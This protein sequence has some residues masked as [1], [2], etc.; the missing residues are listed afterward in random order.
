MATLDSSQP[1][2][3]RVTYGRSSHKR[4]QG[5]NYD[6]LFATSHRSQESTWDAKGTLYDGKNQ[7]PN[8]QGQV[9]SSRVVNADAGMNET[10]LHTTVSAGQK[11]TVTQSVKPKVAKRGRLQSPLN[12][13]IPAQARNTTS[14]IF[15]VP[16]SKDDLES[17]KAA[18]KQAPQTNRFSHKSSISTSSKREDL[19]V[20][21]FSDTTESNELG[22]HSVTSTPK[23][24]RKVVIPMPQ[25]G[26]SVSPDDDDFFRPYVSLRA[27]NEHTALP[28]MLSPPGRRTNKG[29]RSPGGTCARLNRPPT[30][31]LSKA[32]G[33]QVAKSLHTEDRSDSLALCKGNRG[34]L[35]NTK[36]SKDILLKS[37]H[38]R[39]KETSAPE[40]L[41]NMVSA[42]PALGHISLGSPQPLDEIVRPGGRALSPALLPGR[43]TRLRTPPLVAKPL[44]NAVVPRQ[45]RR[46][47]RL[48]AE[49]ISTENDPKISEPADRS[50][51]GHEYPDPSEATVLQTRTLDMLAARP[52]KRLID[53][54]AAGVR[55]PAAG[56]GL[57]DRGVNADDMVS[58]D[59]QM[60]LPVN[61][62]H[63]L[64]E[65]Q[66][67][68]KFPNAVVPVVTN[69]SLGNQRG[70]P[71]ITYAH[72]RSFLKDSVLDET[73]IFD[74]PLDLG[75]GTH[76][77]G[78]GRNAR[79]DGPF[80][81]Q[82]QSLGQEQDTIDDLNGGAIRSIHEL[83]EAGGNRRFLNE[84]EALFEDIEDRST[85]SL[86]RRRSAL[87][88]LGSKLVEKSFARRF[89]DNG[90]S[91][92]LLV[93]LDAE[94]DIIV[95]TILASVII[96]TM[97][98][99]MV[100]HSV[101]KLH[102]EGATQ[103]LLRL[104]DSDRDISLIAK[105]RR[106]N[107]SKIAQSLVFDF[108][109]LIKESSI[110]EIGAPRRVSPRLI[111]LRCLELIIRQLREEGTTGLIFP[112]E[113][114][115]K[116]AQV[117]VPFSMWQSEIE[118]TATDR[119]ELE[120]ALSILE[121]C[122]I[123]VGYVFDESVLSAES[124]DII[125]R[126]LPSMSRWTE[127]DFNQ[128]TLLTL[129]L[130]LSITNNSSA[131]CDIF[132]KP[133]LLSVLV[134]MV[135]SKFKCLSEHLEE[136]Q[137]LYD[138]DVLVLGLGLLINFAELSDIARLSVLSNDGNCLLEALLRTF[139]E[140]LEKTA[141]ADSMEE[142][143]SNVAFGYLSVLLGSLCQNPD[144]RGLLRSKLPGGTLKPLVYAVDE[145]LQHHKKV[146]DLYDGEEGS[147]SRN[148]FTQRLQLVVDRLKQSE[149]LG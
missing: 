24:R 140:R 119:I 11:Q 93:H 3:K 49:G 22:S 146:D 71:K 37:K 113:T 147:G 75:S 56:K 88:E 18:S 44:G 38:L 47:N 68:A 84:I 135:R 70:G 85:N 61:E 138:L 53:S 126:V 17:R 101:V 33:R 149:G 42:C 31:A 20:F 98:D 118:P 129:R 94:H 132:A 121:S 110:W 40:V 9:A 55:D 29:L 120:L 5:Y 64:T 74:A 76:Y 28:E 114:T 4:V 65:S 115:D 69:A 63:D 95:S 91:Q 2:R 96:L 100:T 148:G 106:S 77:Q 83:R 117:L 128:M 32:Q 122:A 50:P 66:G 125:S 21:D 6:D 143:Q 23:K 45:A 43:D 99:A 39:V 13:Q 10:R 137:R 102:Q 87:L 124:L 25:H 46:L 86:S 127:N 41:E 139:L 12:R 27:S 62:S 19:S 67:S 80:P 34:A 26:S 116:I 54:L 60:R 30:A 35:G 15:D 111:A 51:P 7:V 36:M 59:S 144:I 14:S 130:Y 105:E 52:R 142:S 136:E 108:R 90:L 97:N 73:S 104:L 82:L 112:R 131:I 103:M 141:E 58:M 72:Q 107:M 1:R 123:N 89:V 48:L 109:E 134:G 81:S 8:T 16:S 145:F 92:R 78:G 133:E 57:V 79:G